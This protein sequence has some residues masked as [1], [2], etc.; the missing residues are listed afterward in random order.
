[1]TA[2]VVGMRSRDGVDYERLR[3]LRETDSH[4]GRTAKD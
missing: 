4:S 2:G 1:M 3:L